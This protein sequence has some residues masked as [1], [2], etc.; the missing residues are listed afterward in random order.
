MSWLIFEK[1]LYI[2]LWLKLIFVFKICS[3]YS[4]FFQVGQADRFPYNLVNLVWCTYYCTIFRFKLNFPPLWLEI[5]NCHCLFC[6]LNQGTVYSGQLICVSPTGDT[7]PGCN[8]SKWTIPSLVHHTLTWSC[9]QGST[10]G[11][12]KTSG[13]VY[14]RL[15]PEPE[16]KTL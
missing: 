9:G 14:L 6:L 12:K 4:L 5:Y 2:M 1:R 7:C 8:N 13:Q 16:Q 3:S 15:R 10:G 11:P